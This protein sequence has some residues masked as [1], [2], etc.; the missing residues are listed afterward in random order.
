MKMWKKSEA[1]NVAT[2]K[3]LTAVATRCCHKPIL[4]LRE[5]KFACPWEGYARQLRV[6]EHKDALEGPRH[7]D[8]RE[9]GDE[10][11]Y[12]APDEGSLPGG[13]EPPWRFWR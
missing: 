6:K 4:P 5:R 10:G 9:P 8:I 11:I 3:T 12:G 1:R 13:P 2:Q 7:K